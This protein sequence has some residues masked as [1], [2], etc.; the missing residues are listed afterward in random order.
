MVRSAL[1]VR[2]PTEVNMR[3]STAVLRIL[4]CAGLLALSLAC[5]HERRPTVGRPE[6]AVS[7]RDIFGNLPP[8]REDPATE[9][10]LRPGPT[11]PP[12]AGARERIAFPPETPTRTAPPRPAVGPLGVLRTQPSGLDPVGGA[13]VVSFGQPMVPLSTVGR[14]REAPSPLQ[15]EPRPEGRFRWLGTTTLAFEPAGRLPFATSFV[16]TVPAGTRSAVGGTLA[17]AVRFTFETPALEVVAITPGGSRARLD[18]PIALVFN[19]RIDPEALGRA[20][21]VRAGTSAV[22]TRVVPFAEAAGRGEVGRWIQGV[23]PER[24]LVLAPSRPFAPGTAVSVVVPA[25]TRGAEGPKGLAAD[26]R[27]SFTTYGPLRLGSLECD[28]EEPRCRPGEGLRI[29]ASSSIAPEHLSRLVHVE[30]A[31]DD[32][33]ISAHPWGEPGLSLR[34]AFLPQTRY[35]VTVDAGLRDEFDQELGA[36]WSGE[37]TFGDAYPD[38][39]F[40]LETE[41][42]LEATGPRQVPL[43]VTNVRNVRLR[44]WRLDPEA[45]PRLDEGDF[46]WGETRAV[47]RGLR[48]VVDRSVPTGAARNRPAVVGLGVDEALGDGGRGIILV[49]AS[50]PELRRVDRWASPTRRLLVQVTGLGATVRTDRGHAWVVVT[51]LATARPVE[52]ARVSLRDHDWREMGTTRTGSDGKAVVSVGEVHAGWILVD[53]DGDQIAARVS[54]THAPSAKWV[55]AGIASERGIYRPGER[56]HVHGTL[57]IASRD[58][59]GELSA[60]PRGSALRW[61]V[62]SPEGQAIASGRAPITTHGTVDVEV[63]IPEGADLGSYRLAGTLDPRL[64]DGEDFVSARWQVQEYRA[65]ELE[66]KVAVRDGVALLGSEARA[67]IEANYLFGAPM[68]GAAVSWVVVRR[69]SGFRPPGHET[70]T[71]SERWRPVRPLTADRH[72]IHIDGPDPGVRI[73]SGQGLLD[74]RGRLEL[75]V[76]L[77]PDERETGPCDYT[78]EAEVTDSNRQTVAGRSEITAHP[79]PV[80]LG[81]RTPSW[82][83]TAGARSHAEMVAVDVAG[84]VKAG[85]DVRVEMLRRRV[86]GR[87][88]R[89]AAGMWRRSQTVHEEHVSECTLRSAADPAR[90]DL[91][92]PRPGEYVVRATASGG[93]ARTEI[94]I[95]AT[96]PG[97]TAW[98]QADPGVA[99]LVPDRATYEV[100]ET[101]RVLVKSPFPRSLAVVSLEANG[102]I[103]L[104]VRELASSAESISVPITRAMLPNVALRVVLLRGRVPAAELG[105]PEADAALQDLGRPSVVEGEVKIDVRRDSRAIE[106]AV[107]KHGRSA[108]PGA[109]VPI[110]VTARVGGSPAPGVAI[111]L[112]AVDEAVLALTGAKTP[113]LLEDMYP[114]RHPQSDGSDVRRLLLRREPVVTMTRTIRGR[115]GAAAEGE[116]ETGGGYGRGV[117]DASAPSRPLRERRIIRLDSIN[118]EGREEPSFDLRTRFATTPLF[119]GYLTTDEEGVVRTELELPDNLT[120]FRVI[121]LAADQDRFGSADA[122]VT[123]NKPL[124]LRPSLPRFLYPGDRFDASVTVHNETGRD[125][126]VVVMM[127]AAGVEA[128]GPERQV[129]RLAAGDARELTFAAAPRRPGTARVQFGAVALAGGRG[130]GHETDAV[131]LAVPVLVPASTESFAT[132]GATD[133]SIAQPFEPPEGVL[134]WGGLDV[135]LASTALVGLHDAARNVL[136]YRWEC[137]EQVASRL[138]VLSA[139]RDI[140]PDFGLEGLGSRELVDARAAAA[141]RK[142]EAHQ[143]WDGGFRYWPD[144]R[145]ARLHLSAHV[146]LA[147][148]EAKRA[149][150]ELPDRLLD[151]GLAFLRRRLDNPERDLGE[152]ADLVS[153]AL[154]LRV[155]AESDIRPGAASIEP[156]LR[157]LYDRRS[158]LPLFSQIWLLAAA[159]RISATDP[160]AIELRRALENAAVET[161]AGAH[162]AEDHAEAL[163]MIFHSARETDAAALDALVRIDPRHPLLP[164]IVRGLMQ[165]RIDGHWGST[166]TDAAVLAA[167]RRYHDATE[168]APPNFRA[169]IWV[170]PETT[171]ETSFEGR[172]LRVAEQHIP[173][174]ALRDGGPRDIVLGIEG[175]GRLYYRLGLRTIPAAVELPAEEQGFAVARSYEAVDQPED[176]RQN[177][178]GSIALRAGAVIRVRLTLVVPDDRHHVV[179]DDPLPAGLEAIDL[180][181]ETSARELRRRD[182]DGRVQAAAWWNR[183]YAI[184]AFDHTE[185]RD[186]RVASFADV[187]PAGVYEHTYLARATTPG[188]YLV[189]PA[190]AEEMYAPEL[191]GRT[192]SMH[193]TVE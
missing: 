83:V 94:A 55:V 133:E 91:Q 81:L 86:E 78:I 4:L 34:G 87:W 123:V 102:V 134:D 61:E 66:V 35:R 1:A 64:P 85:L 63:P 185:M 39:A 84:G 181:L 72:V 95:F 80:Y 130:Q 90:C 65:P 67:T 3:F 168:T 163:R 121:A 109:R 45:L 89:D 103:D 147:L 98:E 29:S 79:A 46:L 40:P 16:A 124:L 54:Q 2:A 42:V 144:D 158:E 43:T 156:H 141:I 193:V 161:P 157:R 170:G 164:K 129:V 119:V 140:G 150:F 71:F 41:A 125:A 132:Y 25:G 48:K 12:A 183:W 126:E 131:E 101:A 148:A 50:A 26:W 97:R 149:G 191:F 192:A 139:L 6:L 22:Q 38:I 173:M 20:V 8:P 154:A 171:G 92:P 146:V 145:R 108:R 105:V 100:G 113:A 47:P 114:E 128:L 56:A 176:V 15:I 11:P 104:S 142:L 44:M 68:A 14:V 53:K 82:V 179:L 169:A 127:R 96:G 174:A 74:A 155:L 10:P 112:W 186:E 49:E 160:R 28:S 58:R 76:R 37:I 93:R 62:T 190:R 59:P 162:F 24:A 21:Q 110:E 159:R 73:L 166:Y 165:A 69:P 88:E 70:F 118:I 32:L 115:V 151:R 189:P 51:E 152:Q 143:S 106:L 75:R 107:T 137:A 19:Q 111:A 172:T 178:D 117:P 120:T 7:A 180:G 188:R 122:R 52:G 30:P 177:A 27:G 13:V 99:D 184:F 36:P 60:P 9:S 135:Q 153:Q 77:R 182:L 17:E 138:R 187:L 18:S 57:R 136:E 175:S 167:L 23:L 33:E 116:P 5:P 31:V